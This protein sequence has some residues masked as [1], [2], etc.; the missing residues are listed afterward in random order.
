MIANG[1]I[2]DIAA[3]WSKGLVQREVSRFRRAFSEGRKFHAVRAEVTGKFDLKRTDGFDIIKR[4]ERHARVNLE[5][6]WFHGTIFTAASSS[7]IMGGGGAIHR[8][9]TQRRTRRVHPLVW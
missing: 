1:A 7:I 8:A 3:D 4:E 5:R 2:E 6:V 9:T